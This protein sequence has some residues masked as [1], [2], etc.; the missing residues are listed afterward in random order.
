[1]YSKIVGFLMG[2]FIACQFNLVDSEGIEFGL[3]R[4]LDT[5]VIGV[6]TVNAAEKLQLEKSTNSI[7]EG[8]K[9]VKEPCEIE[10]QQSINAAYQLLMLGNKQEDC[11]IPEGSKLNK[12]IVLDGELLLDF[13][14]ELLNYG[15]NMWEEQLVALILDTAFSF[16]K[17]QYVTVTINGEVKNFVEGTTINRY[18]R[19]KWIERKQSK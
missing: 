9:T 13:S 4:Q 7:G 2:L 16:E 3:I 8:K 10:M 18:T 17:I 1:M 6:E 15:G 11:F 12:V 14:E 19:E 5:E